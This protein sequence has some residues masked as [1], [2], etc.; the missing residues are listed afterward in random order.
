[1]Y[2]QRWALVY[3]IFTRLTN[4]SL[5]EIP[6]HGSQMHIRDFR[7]L[8]FGLRF[9]DRRFCLWRGDATC[10]VIILLCKNLDDFFMFGD[11][12]AL[13]DLLEL[14]IKWRTQC[15]VVYP[16][17]LREVVFLAARNE[18]LMLGFKHVNSHPNVRPSIL[19]IAHVYPCGRGLLLKEAQEVIGRENIV[20]WA[21]LVAF[22]YRI[23]G[24]LFVNRKKPLEQC[25]LMR[26]IT[27]ASR[28][29]V[30]NQFV[31]RNGI[32]SLFLKTPY[33]IDD[34]GSD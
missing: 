21:K 10:R 34:I 28:E 2:Q 4:L 20:C 27:F 7:A 12:N 11:R 23:M 29:D 8:A 26:I 33:R 22:R 18:K 1:M 32:W 19:E 16:H 6:Q 15:W 24:Y 5:G 31:F 30:C 13:P 3:H 17:H 14:F 25:Y 9:L